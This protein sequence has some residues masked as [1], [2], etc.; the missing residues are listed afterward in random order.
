VSRGPSA[1][2]RE[3]LAVLVASKRS[4]DVTGELLPALGLE[5]TDVTRRSMLR[6]LRLLER[7]GLVTLDRVPAER[8][9]HPRLLASARAGARGELRGGDLQRARGSSPSLKGESEGTL[10][11]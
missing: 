11:G 8:G 4:L 7:R 6:A 3:A 5:P 9:G 1:R 2:Q 10:N